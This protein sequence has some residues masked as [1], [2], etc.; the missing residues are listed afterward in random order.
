MAKSITKRT[1]V[2]FNNIPINATYFDDLNNM[3]KNKTK[4]F[5]ERITRRSYWQ[6]R[7]VGSLKFNAVVGNPPYQEMD[8]GARASASPLYHHFVT[9]AKS[10]NPE[11]IS[12]IVPTRWYVGGKG[13]DAFQDEMLNDKH[14]TKIYDCLTP[15]D[16][17]PN[18]NIRGGICYFL[19]DTSYANSEDFL[20]VITYKNNKI[21]ADVLRP[22]K[23]DGVDIFLRDGEA[24]NI[25]K[26][27]LGDGNNIMISHH[28]S[29]RKPFGLE[30]SFI[31]NENFHEQK[32]DLK[33]PVKCYGRAK[34][35][36]YVEDELIK[37]R[38]EWIGKWKVFLPYANNIG[39]ELNDDNQNT[40]IGEP[41]SIC[42]ETFLVAGVDLN[43]NKDSANNLSIYLRTKFARFLLSLAKSS[44]HATAKTYK[45]V[46][47]QNFTM[48]SDINWTKSIQNIDEQLFQKYNLS[49]AEINYIE[50]K[51]KDMV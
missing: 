42:T 40:F 23:I 28:I 38:R 29:P 27:V 31:K 50:T 41:Y 25:L 6:K 45:F 12:F 32:D 11:F 26:K 36:G 37:N 5:I 7:G 39:T 44:Q 30:S 33:S 15:E 21:I 22:M 3:M 17:F 43:L 24:I 16:I 10:I 13:L 19:H 4:Q 14:I 47:I 8:G 46:P 9:T 35:I 18:T 20:R 49:T 48:E 1:L 34:T 51:I 2:G